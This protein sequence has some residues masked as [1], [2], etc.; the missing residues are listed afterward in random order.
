MN[1]K[2]ILKMLVDR[3]K[4]ALKTKHNVSVIKILSDF[5]DEQQEK[6]LDFELRITNI[7]IEKLSMAVLKDNYFNREKMERIALLA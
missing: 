4:A 3:I 7:I 2:E 1:E 6:D 5:R